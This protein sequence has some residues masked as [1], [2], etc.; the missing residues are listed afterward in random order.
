MTR[1]LLYMVDAMGQSDLFVGLLST[2]KPRSRKVSRLY[3]EAAVSR[4][5]SYT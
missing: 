5:S 4:V 1:C 2:L 3:V